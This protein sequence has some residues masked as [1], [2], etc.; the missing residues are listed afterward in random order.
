MEK[1]NNIYVTSIDNKNRGIFSN[2]NN[3]ELQSKLLNRNRGIIINN[4]SQS[5]NPSTLSYNLSSL[6]MNKNYNNKN[7]KNSILKV[8]KRNLSLKLNTKLKSNS[9][10]HKN[11]H[12]NLI[13]PPIKAELDYFN[14]NLDNNKNIFMKYNNAYTSRNQKLQNFISKQEFS[15]LIP[16]TIETKEN[17]KYL[18]YEMNVFYRRKKTKPFKMH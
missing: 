8:S 6:L 18:M 11:K 7:N 15:D 9:K 17:D 12:P 16:N 1:Q 4:N 13:L 3:Y 14:Y 2:K 5:R 10:S